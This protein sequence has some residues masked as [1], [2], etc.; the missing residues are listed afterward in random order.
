MGRPRVE[1]SAE[2]APT[3]TVPPGRPAR[4]ALW[5]LIR[6]AK[7]G[8]PLTPVTVAVPSPYAGLSLRRELGRESGLV[9]VRFLPL[10]RIAELMGA[11]RLA[12]EGRVPLTGAR[13]AE[14]VHAALASAPGPFAAVAGQRSTEEQ[15]GATFAELRRAPRSAFT[16]LSEGGAWTGA[17][18]HL[19]ERFRALTEGSYDEEDLA[20]AAAAATRDVSPA[21]DELGTVILFLPRPL[22]VAEASLT[23]ALAAHRRV[24][25]VA[26]PSDPASDPSPVAE[27]IVQAADPEDEAR[28]AIR[29]LLARAEAGTPFHRLAILYTVTE[30]YA[31]LVPELL[32]AAAIPWTGP[33]PRRLGDSATG[34]VLG[35]VLDLI[36]DDFARDAVASWLGSGPILDASGRRVPGSRWDLVSRDAGI[37]SGAGQWHDRLDRSRHK[38]EDTLRAARGDDDEPD[39]HVGRLERDLDHVV[40]LDAFIHE[41]LERTRPPEPTTWSSLSGWARALLARYLGGEGHRAD[42]P[43]RELDAARRIESA[44]GDLDSLDDLGTAVDLARFRDALETTLL[45]STTHVGRFGTGIYV[46]PLQTAAGTEFA[47]VAVLGC[48]EGALPPRG[49]DD[50]FLPDV[51]RTRAGSLVTTAERRVERR[52]DFVAALA[53]AD[54]TL[55]CFPRADPRAQQGRLPARWVLETATAHAGR[56]VTAEELRALEPQPWLDVVASFEQGVT[57]DAE[58]G[59]LT[60]RDLRSLCEWRDARRP[61]ADHPL[62]RGALGQGFT[63]AARRASDRFTAFS[64]NVGASALLAHGPDRPISATALQDWATCPFRYLLGRVL[65]VR[66]VPRPEA[67]ETISAL[68]EGT[69]VHA[70]LESFVRERPPTTP[71]QRW[72]EAD[73]TRMLEHVARHCD[74][75]EARGITGRPLLWRLARRR[76]ER[77][78][79]RFLAVDAE[80]RRAFDAVPDAA[81]LEVPFG[82]DGQPGVTVPLAGGRNVT[83]RGRIDRIDRSPDD[84]RVVVYD[85]KTGRVDHDGALADDPVHAGQRL[86]LPIYGLAAAARTGID[87]AHAYYW[88]TRADTL[89]DARVGYVLDESVRARFE[90]VIN[91]IIDGVDAGCFP[92]YPGPRDFDIRVRSETF[93]NC[94]WC[95]YDRLCPVDRGTA[96]ERQSADPDIAAFWKLELGSEPTDT[97]DGDT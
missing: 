20:L 91:T 54:E 79:L 68:D 27:R 18:I 76:V 55:L 6:D 97:P 83:F 60:E 9:N 63:L 57:A 73:R 22:S 47:T 69:L 31:R 82:M 51:D 89:D 24:F 19:Y 3:V 16:A 26:S 39:W 35:G 34:R 64:G 1:G 14:A 40:Q 13:R 46:G 52:R 78:A 93:A 96:W 48:F 12:G 87:D 42:W 84:Q 86:Q 74:A 8:D 28:A 7:A 15:L 58:P 71:D 56:P 80:F 85:Y 25:V 32:D 90:D 88:F 53:A 10:A 59:S 45:T 33:S 30:P 92:A 29:R 94:L 50:P 70:I 62:A 36:G 61:L 67:T 49:R 21:L 43:E 72:D 77:T 66:E 17:V 4:E 2:R 44:L 37:V 11:P 5:E 95:P 23:E 75:A 81:D 65:H 38:L 41:L